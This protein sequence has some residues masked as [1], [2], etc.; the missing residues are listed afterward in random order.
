[1]FAGDLAGSDELY[2]QVA[3]IDAPTAASEVARALVNRVVNSTLSGD[4]AETRRRHRVASDY[5]TRIGDTRQTLWLDVNESWYAL[6]DGRWDESL[7]RAEAFL[8]KVAPLGGHYLEDAVRLTR[9]EIHASRGLEGALA[10]LGWVA[11][12]FDETQDWQSLL[13]RLMVSAHVWSILGEEAEVNALL[14]RVREITFVPNTPG[15]G[16]TILSMVVRFGR[17][18]EWSE[19][20]ANTADTPRMRAAHLLLSGR[21]VE[22]A[23]AYLHVSGACDEAAVRMLAA[24]QFVAEGRRAEADV[25]LQRALAFYRAVGASRIVRRAETLLA[26]AG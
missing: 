20:L 4:L 1:M 18:A 25:Q 2:A 13:P 10:D 5:A 6:E 21:T 14:D 26:A 9:A 15:L 17:A 12:H 11:G 19:R 8:A 23:D 7:A 24:E 22:A 3:A 16:G